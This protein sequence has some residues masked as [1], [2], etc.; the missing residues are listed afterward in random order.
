MKRTI[1]SLLTILLIAGNARPQ[2]CVI[3]RNI[4]GFGQ[5]NLTDKGFSTSDWQLNITNRYFKSHRDFKGTKDQNTPEADVHIIYSYALDLSITRMLSKGWSLGLSLPVASNTRSATVEHGGAGTPRHS[6][7]SFGIGDVRITAYKWLVNPSVKQNWNL[8]IGLGL[9]LPTGDYK[10]QDYFYRNDSTKVLAPVSASIQLGDGG[11][12]IITELNT[13]YVFSSRRTSL[14]GNFYYLVNPREQ[15]GVSATFG[16]P[17]TTLQVKTGSEINS[18]PDQYSIRAG[19]NFNFKKLLFSMGLRDEGIPVY[20]LIGGSNGV[21]RAG[22]NISVEPGIVYKIK[23]ISV[24][25]YIPI[26]VSRNIKQTVPDKKETEIG[27]VYVLRMGGSPNYLV[28]VGAS[29]K[30]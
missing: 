14:Y 26:I 5:Y 18:V 30:L 11:T 19:V 25:A 9:K 6:T 7:H 20:D 8:Q 4:S 15:N 28:F 3:V 1:I 2:G 17:P 24:F 22:H 13:F 27:H 16:K 29:F 10:Y 23:K 21:R 12:G